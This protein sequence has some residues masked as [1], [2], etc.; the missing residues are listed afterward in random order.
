[1]DMT[2]NPVE[3]KYI[4]VIDGDVF[5]FPLHSTNDFLKE[6]NADHGVRSHAIL[7]NGMEL[8]I[9]A[10]RHHYCSP[11]DSKSTEYTSVEVGMNGRIKELC[12]HIEWEDD[13][14]S[15]DKFTVYSYVP[16]LL[17]DTVINQN[18]GIV[19]IRGDE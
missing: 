7:K 10:S 19:R 9:Q 14:P 2:S 8:S 3:L 5:H 18:G 16:V 1:M 11:R 17:L 12:G 6:V 15:D 4:T 13:D